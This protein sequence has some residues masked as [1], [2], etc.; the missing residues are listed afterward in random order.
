MRQESV[1]DEGMSEQDRETTQNIRTRDLEQMAQMAQAQQF[2]E[3]Q[4]RLVSRTARMAHAG[5]AGSQTSE[6]TEGDE[7]PPLRR[8]QPYTGV[9][10][11]HG[12]GSEKKNDTLQEALNA[13]G[14]WFNH[15]AGLALRESG[16]DRIWMQ[17]HLLEENNP[18]VPAS[19]ATVELCGHAGPH[20]EAPDSLYL[21]MREVWWAQ[22]FGVPS[23]RSALAWARLQFRQETYGILLPIGQ[24]LTIPARAVQNAR[25]HR[26]TAAKPGDDP[27]QSFGHAPNSQREHRL[28][29]V[30]RAPLAVLL[31][32]YD[33]VQDVWKTF[34]W[35]LGIPLVMLLLW[36]AGIVRVLAPLPGFRTLLRGIAALI[37]TVSL[38]WIAAMQVYLLDYTNSASIRQRF[39]RQL[40][41]F[42]Q[43]DRCQRIV[44]IAHSMGAVVAYEGLTTALAENNPGKEV[45][46]ICL[47]Q[48]LRRI[49]PLSRTDA[50]RLRGV[51]P[52]NVRWIHF[53]ARYDPVAAGDLD[54]SALPP[55]RD[56]NDPDQPN[57][58][59]A[60][61]ETLKRV[62]NV[63]VVN[64]DSLFTDHVSYWENSEQVIGPIASELV[65]GTPEL[66][67]LVEAHLATADDVLLRR[68][69]VAWRSSLAL[70]AGAAAGLATLYYGLPNARLGHAIL[71]D[72]GLL[73]S[74]ITFLTAIFAQIG[75]QLA[76]AQVG[77]NPFETVVAYLYRAINQVGHISDG[78]L[79]VI[80]ALLVVAI[81]VA[82]VHNIFPVP[83][84]FVFRGPS[85]RVSV[86]P[87]TP[88]APR[89][90]D[91]PQP[92]MPHVSPGPMKPP[93][94]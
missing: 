8:D 67:T 56:W 84:P 51:L 6:A 11:I 66:E 40:Q 10:I 83:S 12:I 28:P 91:M 31:S 17:T 59:A 80:I 44:V 18:D 86:R 50:H 41:P 92:V 27:S 85:D 29:W 62:E 45:T 33:F 52:G 65:R 93:T 88:K 76:K 68:W 43:D 37:E 48:A 74:N 42:L 24:R 90:A 57:P 7:Q 5:S 15:T 54:T 22:A 2:S 36:V 87:T 75:R 81:V 73:L 39:Q 49:W 23:T 3:Q 32:L 30:V 89:S 4:Q 1:G 26:K 77:S 61:R 38:H 79:T 64:H 46:F 72:I 34:Q 69:R 78:L 58:D 35:L 13:L 14:Y 53:W 21:E 9:V 25:R 70:I 71:N 60:I 82:L 55:A 20:G 63:R 19:H 47:S 16:P 94:S